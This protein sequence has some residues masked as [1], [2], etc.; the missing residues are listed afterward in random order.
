MR[1]Y[2]LKDGG[3]NWAS[4]GVDSSHV[5]DIPLSGTIHIGVDEPID[6][7]KTFSMRLI[8]ADGSDAVVL[9]TSTFTWN[10]AGQNA[11]GNGPYDL[12]AGTEGHIAY[13]GLKPDTQYTLEING[14]IDAPVE[15][16]ADSAAHGGNQ[17]TQ[18][19]SATF[20][21]QHAPIAGSVRI[22]GQ[23]YYGN[24]LTADTSLVTSSSGG[25]LG[26]FQYAWMRNGADIPGATAAT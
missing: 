7:S 19:W 10:A 20:T 21:T 25:S 3:F 22:N 5:T 2:M 12:L 17:M 14:L 23:P 15:A 9:N 16:T 6:T 8:P 4:G 18:A 13:E 24:T 26:A 11:W 1:W